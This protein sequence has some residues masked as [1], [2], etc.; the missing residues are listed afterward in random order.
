MYDISTG[1]SAT[2][3]GQLGEALRFS[4]QVGLALVGQGT[5]GALTL[6]PSSVDFGTVAVGFPAVQEI[7]LLNQSGGKLCYSIA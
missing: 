6:E 5:I 7:T 2:A 3:S 1:P 4:Q